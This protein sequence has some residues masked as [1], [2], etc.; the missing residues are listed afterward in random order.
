MCTRPCQRE[1]TPDAIS[2]SLTPSPFRAVS[3]ALNAYQYASCR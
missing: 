3:R 1:D 2:S